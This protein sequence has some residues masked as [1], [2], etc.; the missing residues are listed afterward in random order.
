ML[1]CT[2]LVRL[3]K[4]ARCLSSPSWSIIR[5]RPSYE[6]SGIRVFHAVHQEMPA[7]VQCAEF[8]A[9]RLP[10]ELHQPTIQLK[11][12]FVYLCDSGFIRPVSSDCLIPSK[13][14]VGKYKAV[15]I[16]D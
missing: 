1:A 10:Q 14:T 3:Q 12:C 13:F 4:P 11:S 6:I 5:A 9:A 15:V 2:V 7:A 16:L 8:A